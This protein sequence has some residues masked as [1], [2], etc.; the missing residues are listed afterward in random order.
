MP[1]TQPMPNCWKVIG[2]WGLDDRLTCPHL[3][4]FIHCKNCEVYTQA[5]R[6]LLERALPG[7]YKQDW[8]QVLSQ[9]KR[10]RTRRHNFGRNLSN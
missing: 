3:E 9:K 5:G 6:T 1:I 7:N 10:R 8:T 2:V 4:R